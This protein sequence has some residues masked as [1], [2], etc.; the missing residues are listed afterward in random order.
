MKIHH[1]PQGSEE[2]WDAH[3]GIPTA[4]NFDKIITP[5][6]MKPSAQA[7]D[8]IC[9][10]IG[11]LACPGSIMPTNYVSPAM[12]NGIALEPQ[13]RRWYEFSQNVKVEQC[14]ICITDDGRFG[15]SPDALCGE[16]GA[17]ELKCPTAKTQV[18]YLLDGVLPAEYRAQVHGE[19]I[20]TGRAWVDFVSYCPGLDPFMT[21]VTRDEFTA[22]LEK[23]LESFWTAY[24]AA[25]SK[26]RLPERT[27]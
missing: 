22:A 11:Q 7:D 5:K 1:M 2:W 25:L 20:V 6:T 21:R 10:L 17:L 24:Q 8:L 26:I 12:L 15:A 27:L 14:G 13:A 16:D 4:S 18:K 23:C 9:E 3:R 19:L